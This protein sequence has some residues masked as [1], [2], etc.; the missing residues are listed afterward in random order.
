[1]KDTYCSARLISPTGIRLF[2]FS[3]APFEKI[4]ATLEKDGKE[5]RV[6]P[7]GRV[8]SMGDLILISFLLNSPLP[9]GH[10]YRL[11]LPSYGAVPLDVSEAT[12][13]PDFDK[14][15]SY[16]GDDLGG[17]LHPDG[18]TFALWAP[19]ASEVFLKIAKA[20]EKTFERIPMIRGDR[21]VYRLSLEGNY[22]G[23][24]YTYVIYQSGTMSESIDPYGRASSVNAEESVLLDWNKLHVD[25]HEEDVAKPLGKTESVIYE[26][27]VRDLTSDPN[28]SVE[29]KG[30]YLGLAEPGRKTAGGHPFGIDY[31]KFLGVTHL[32]LLPILD[33]GS[34][35]ERHPE[36]GYNWGYDPV[37]WFVP[38]GGLAS[39]NGDPRS[40]IL[41]LKKLVAALHQ[42][43]IK[44]IF[45]VVYNHIYHY[46]YSSLEKSVPN[47]FFRRRPSGKLQN[48][49]GCGDDVASERPMAAHLI[50]SSAKWLID[51]YGADGF[52]FDLMGLLDADLLKKIASY[53]KAKKRDF[54]L[55]GEGWDMGADAHK[56][57]GT[58]A[59]A[60]ILPEYSFFNDFFREKS[61]SLSSGDL[62]AFQ[63]WKAAWASMCV[64]FLVPRRFLDGEQSIN[65]VECHD[66]YAYF[67]FLKGKRPDLSM[68]EKLRR[69][70]LALFMVLIS[71]GV[72]FLHSG[73]E[74]AFDKAGDRNSYRSGDEVNGFPAK[75]LDER[76]DMALF[77]RDAIAFRKSVPG[78]SLHT[79]SDVDH[80]ADVGEKNGMLRMTFLKN[81]LFGSYPPFAIYLNPSEEEKSLVYPEP[82]EALF[83]ENGLLKRGSLIGKEF[84]IPA[85]GFLVVGPSPSEIWAASD[86]AEYQ[87]V[88]ATVMTRQFAS[89]SMIQ[90]E[91][92]VGFVRAGKIFK[93]L[94][95]EGIV[96]TEAEPGAEGCKVLSHQN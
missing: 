92:S 78:F 20:G 17:F 15:Y 12:S 88:K 16:A 72:P 87:S 52:R 6:L 27:H 39:D 23:A 49:S 74:I 83:S 89:V 29:Q 69:A 1:M 21:G 76:W 36:K 48:C 7:S 60:P 38:E 3:S 43:G 40:R 82:H 94:Q 65:Y 10:S 11:L 9:L 85:G 59:N 90:R 53:G 75:L 5:E 41:Q 2:L 44:V 33:Y 84:K 63:D 13:F 81:E 42:S 19:L 64:D 96:A 67:A 4:S 24:Y 32:E 35:D 14:E 79:P 73:Q 61:K 54:Y 46:E 22:E 70:K 30:K 50:Y 55:G 47:Y 80:L 37:Q 86:E 31:L 58:M 77:A 66:D 68:E 95:D 18:A 45:D 51:E 28:S 8:S 62:S 56:P 91:F 26:A 93:R 57:M 71:L 25:L 34:V